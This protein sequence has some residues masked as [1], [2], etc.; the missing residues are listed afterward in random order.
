MIW[1][2]RRSPSSWWA[3]AS[4][5][6][7]VRFRSSVILSNKLDAPVATTVMGGGAC[8]GDSDI[9]DHRHDRDA[10]LPRLQLSPADACDLLIA[11]GCRFSDRV[12]PV[13]RAPLPD[14]PRSSTSTSTGRRS[15]RTSRPTTTSSATPAG[16]WS[17]STSELTRARLTPTGRSMS[18]PINGA[19]LYDEAGDTL[20]PQQMLRYHLRSLCPQG[21]HRRHR[22]GPASDVVRSV[23]PLRP[24][25]SAADLRRLRHHGLRPGRRHGR[26][27]GQSRTRPLST[28][29]GDGCFR[30]NC[31]ELATVQLL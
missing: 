29:T 28:C 25:R 23:F 4:S 22:R 30:M 24:P 14:R 3:A 9:P 17:C 5:A 15:T 19:A 20:T 12:A 10:R 11:V 6:A 21:Y 27:G 2:R 18:S 26:Q 16:C 8:P 31:H 7:R 13:T 1:T